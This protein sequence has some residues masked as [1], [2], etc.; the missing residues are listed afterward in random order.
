MWTSGVPFSEG[1]W[2]QLDRSDDDTTWRINLDWTPNDDTLIY[3]SQTTGFRSGGMNLVFFSDPGKFPAEHLTAYELGYKGSLL[4]GR[5]QLN[6]AVYFYDYENVHSFGNGVGEFGYT[7]RIFAAPKAEMM[8]WDA[9]FIWLMTDRITVGANWSYV[10]SE[11]T[12][13]VFIIDPTNPQLPAS[14]FDVNAVPININGNQML[15]VPEGKAGGYAQYTWPVSFGQLEF[16]ANWSWI[17]R[18]YYS[19]FENDDQSAEPYQRFD[20]RATWTSND[21]GWMVA[22]FVNNVF[23]EIGLRQI[24]QYGATEESN[25]MRTGTATDPRLWGLEVRYKFGAAR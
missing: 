5:L 8:G 23:D 18:V 14:L 17:S 19:V 15:R 3:L 1:L 25:Y 12:D 22:T 2:R 24:E 20:L 16:L 11:Y 21:G 9:D 7:T 6:T 13:D 10:D 4:D